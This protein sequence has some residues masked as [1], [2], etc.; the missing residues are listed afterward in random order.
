MSILSF[1]HIYTPEEAIAIDIKR[2]REIESNTSIITELLK[3]ALEDIRCGKV[4]KLKHDLFN[5]KITDLQIL[6]ELHKSDKEYDAAKKSLELIELIITQMDA[7]NN[8]EKN[9]KVDAQDKLDEH[10]ISRLK[11][12]V[13]TIEDTMSNLLVM[14]LEHVKKGEEFLHEYLILLNSSYLTKDEFDAFDHKYSNFIK[15]KPN[16]RICREAMRMLRKNIVIELKNQGPTLK[17]QEIIYIQK[18]IDIYFSSHEFRSLLGKFSIPSGEKILVGIYGS[19]VTGYASKHSKFKGLPTD[20]NRISDVDV[21]IVITDKILS[22]FLTDAPDKLRYGLYYGPYHEDTLSKT[23]PFFGLYDYFRSS[24]F[25]GRI[26]RKIG[27]IIVNFDF[28]H[29]NLEKDKHVI[30]GEYYT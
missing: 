5:S 14:E 20:E 21:G 11:E 19:M 9:N 8:V 29:N 3:N 4:N 18:K 10:D 17:S 7:R 22:K 12:L 16:R 2:I 25:A 27:F 6:K 15:S 23:G 28:Y 26:D 1:F 13:K 24:S 30:L